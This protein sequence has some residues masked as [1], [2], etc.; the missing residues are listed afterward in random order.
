MKTS[1]LIKKSQAK[2]GAPGT[3][4]RK[5][6]GKMTLAKARAL[7]NKPGATTLDKKQANFFINMHSEEVAANSVAGGGVDMAPNAKKQ[8]MI[9]VKR[10]KD[11]I[12]KKEQ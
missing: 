10:F 3:L 12:K 9:F 2:R 4:K 11:Y 5:V 6:K 1:D 8:K 7:K